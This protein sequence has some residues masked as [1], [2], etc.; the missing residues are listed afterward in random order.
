MGL[1]ARGVDPL[2]AVDNRLGLDV[3]DELGRPVSGRA[4]LE[5]LKQASAARTAQN[6]FASSLPKA[7]FILP[8]LELAEGCRTWLIE[9]VDSLPNPHAWAS[10]PTP[11]PRVP[12][13]LLALAGIVMAQAASRLRPRAQR[14][15]ALCCLCRREVLRC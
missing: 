2:A 8:A 3:R 1:E 13:L 5:Q 15:L 4:V 7:R 12:A 6:A 11:R 10:M 14:F 9:L